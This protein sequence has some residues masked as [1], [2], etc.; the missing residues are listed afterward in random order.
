MSSYRRRLISSS[1]CKVL[2]NGRRIIFYTAA[3]AVEPDYF[4]P[5]TDGLLIPGYVSAI[6]KGH[7]EHLVIADQFLNGFREQNFVDLG[8]NRHVITKNSAQRRRRRPSD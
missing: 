8:V 5:V 6:L 2:H 3:G 4:R 7:L 1:Y